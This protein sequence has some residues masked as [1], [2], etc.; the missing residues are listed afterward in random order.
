MPPQKA[1]A[2]VGPLAHPETGFVDVDKETLQHNSYPNVFALG[3]V[4][5]LP[6]S[7]TAAAVYS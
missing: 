7:K 6:T 1:H 4:A 2:F 3:D 5:N